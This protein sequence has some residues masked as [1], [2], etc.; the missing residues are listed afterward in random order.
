MDISTTSERDV[1]DCVIVGAGPAGLTAGLYLRRFHRNIRI[2]DAGTS[3]AAYIRRS[4]NIAGFPEG[5][6]GAQLLQRM[7]QHL[8]QVDGQVIHDT[9]SRVSKGAEGLFV[10]SLSTEHL[11][12]RSVI[13]CT[14]VVD[15]RPVL[16]G[17]GE[18]AA[19]DLLR[20]CPVCD[21]YE[22][23]GKS[24]GVIG[25]SSHGAKEALFLQRFSR[26]V[27]FIE[28]AGRPSEL[29]F[30]ATHAFC[31]NRLA[32]SAQHVALT[33]DRKVFVTMDDGSGHRFDVLY[34][35]LGVDPCTQ[36]A[37]SLDVRLD[38]RGGLVTDSHGRTSVENLYAAGDVVSALDQ[39]SVAVGQAAIAA[40]AVHNSLLTSAV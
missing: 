14:G 40:T 3:R 2:I 26:S 30:E 17:L 29:D 21:G 24:I 39:I 35:A 9:V 11:W 22:F 27:W 1:L 7:N 12:A 33:Q 8:R 19:A 18:V 37:A 10:V 23:T 38:A 28:I 20:A 15:R 5:V 36:L 13:L 25:N 31:V 34:A 6:G 16:P 4:N 32:G